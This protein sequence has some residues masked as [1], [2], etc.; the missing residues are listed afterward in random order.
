MD[1]RKLLSDGGFAAQGAVALGAT[2]SGGPAEAHEAVRNGFPEGSSRAEREHL[3]T[4]DELDLEI[5]LVHD[6][7]RFAESHAPDVKVHWPDGRT[8]EG[9]D[10]HVADIQAM[11]AWAPDTR[12]FNQQVGL[13][14]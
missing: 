12:S 13:T 2:V 8:T 1:R 10:P 7:P 14:P 6:W 11:I 3:R 9:L 5:F 4:F